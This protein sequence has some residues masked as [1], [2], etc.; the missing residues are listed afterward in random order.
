[1]ADTRMGEGRGR[2][3]WDPA[4]EGQ[5]GIRIRVLRTGVRVRF[6]VGFGVGFGVR[7]GVRFGFQFRLRF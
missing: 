5:V 3:P 1:M 6:G 2:E 4:V 7:F